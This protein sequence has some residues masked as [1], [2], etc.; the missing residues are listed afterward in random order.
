MRAG[1][2]SKSD[3]AGAAE[4]SRKR[5]LEETGAV[6]AE[7]S[8]RLRRNSNGSATLTCLRKD[9]SVTWQRQTGQD[10]LVFPGHDLTH[11]AVEKTLGYA[12][13]FF[14]LIAAGWEIGDFAA[15]WPRGPLP[16]EAR[17]V[18]LLVGLFDSERRMGERWTAQEFC[19]R[20]QAYAAARRSMRKAAEA[21]PM[22]SEENLDK[23]RSLRDEL[24]ARWAATRPGENLELTF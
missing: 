3:L 13:G 19:D 22:L 16:A 8:L 2:A 23:V 7:L 9:G 11:F 24:L 12:Q 20:G 10:G 14:G 17:A 5:P 6:M 15:P 21:M 18:E 4:L 1:K